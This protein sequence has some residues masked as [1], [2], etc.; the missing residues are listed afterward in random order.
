MPVFPFS[1]PSETSEVSG[2]ASQL[3]ALL[4]PGPLW[5]LE[6]DSNV[7]KTLNGISEELARVEG[8]GA[9]LIDETDPRTAS[10]TIGEWET[11]VGLPDERVTEIPATLAARQIAVTQKYAG[12]GGQNYSFFELLV[13]SCGWELLSITKFAAEILRVGFRVGDRVYGADFAYT[14]EM[15]IQDT[16]TTGALSTA[17]LER[18]IRHA[19]HSHI[20]VIFT[21]V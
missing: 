17:D 9:N 11:M 20:T 2:Y 12:R 15:T 1:P 8:R 3:A 19:T 14:I 6:L 16:G 21:Y 4:P 5:N 10:E 18:V 13:A 7:R